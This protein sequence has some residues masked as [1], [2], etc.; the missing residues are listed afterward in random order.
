MNRILSSKWMR[1]SLAPLTLFT[2]SAL[3]TWV[4]LSSSLTPASDQPVKKEQAESK[5]RK[6]ASMVSESGCLTDEN[7]IADIQRRRADMEAKEKELESR[8]SELDAKEK[9]VV[10]QLKKIEAVRDEIKK[11]EELRSQQQGAKV[12][13]VVETFE[14]MTPKSVSSM[15]AAMDENLAVEAM[16]RISTAKLAK[17]LNLMEPAKSARLTERLVGMRPEL[18]S[19][20]SSSDIEQ[21][22]EKKT[23]LKTEAD[24]ERQPAGENQL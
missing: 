21:E 6:P 19:K 4:V 9:A 22:D 1:S 13:K 17:V 24:S 15:L 14:T 12:G 20:N 11:T 5:E 2:L 3:G 7:A 18:Q 23:S 8:L 10:E 16:N